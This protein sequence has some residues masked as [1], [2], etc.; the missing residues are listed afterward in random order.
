MTES[1]SLI[2]TSNKSGKNRD[3]RCLNCRFKLKYSG[4]LATC[5]RCS[6]I[7]ESICYATISL[8][9]RCSKLFIL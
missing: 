8:K 4:K 9:T 2:F 7:K 1:I 5:F 6:G 3:K